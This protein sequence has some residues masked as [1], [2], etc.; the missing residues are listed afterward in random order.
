M[1]RYGRDNSIVGH[2]A[3]GHNALCIDN[4]LFKLEPTRNTY[5]GWLCC[6]LSPQAKSTTIFSGAS[7]VPPPPS[8]E[9]ADFLSHASTR[10]RRVLALGQI[11]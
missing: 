10:N 3:L 7:L 1:C 5:I 9:G 8:A 6:S 2:T 4:D 11:P